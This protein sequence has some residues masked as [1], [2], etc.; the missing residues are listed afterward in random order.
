MGYTVLAWKTNM[1]GS[2]FDFRRSLLTWVGPT[3]NP[4]RGGGI[5]IRC[6]WRVVFDGGLFPFARWVIH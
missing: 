3:T 5:P 2:N 1:E 6:P 4:S